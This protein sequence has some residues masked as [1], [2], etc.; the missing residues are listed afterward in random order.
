M[1]TNPSFSPLAINDIDWGG[2]PSTSDV[3]WIPSEKGISTVL[4][5][6]KDSSDGKMKWGTYVLDLATFSSRFKSDWTVPAGMGFWY[7]RKGAAFTVKLPVDKL[8]E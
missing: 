4:R 7:N 8:S 1:I 6:A 2:K 5:W 3:V